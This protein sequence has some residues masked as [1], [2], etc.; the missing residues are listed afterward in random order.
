MYCR[1]KRQAYLICSVL[2]LTRLNSDSL[3]IF[4]Y[5][6]TIGWRRIY[7]ILTLYACFFIIQYSTKMICVTVKSGQ[8]QIV[9]KIQITLKYVFELQNTFRNWINTKYK[10]H[11]IYFNYAFQILVF[12]ILDNSEYTT[13]NS[14]ANHDAHLLPH[15][16][17]SCVE[18]L[19]DKKL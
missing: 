4:S 14:T 15:C 11:A 12:H 18:K 16:I 9:F 7:I 10:L 19:H 17:S 3:T 2:K 6:Q 5:W 8:T 13:C 1:D